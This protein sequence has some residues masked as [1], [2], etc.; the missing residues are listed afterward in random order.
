MEKIEREKEPKKAS[1]PVLCPNKCVANVAYMHV[2]RK[3]IRNALATGTIPV[4]VCVCV[5]VAYMQCR[6]HARIYLLFILVTTIQG[7]HDT[8]QGTVG[9]FET[10]DTLGTH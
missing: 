1:P 6:V 5:C 10:R 8:V 2:T 4:C 9:R 7:F 3:R